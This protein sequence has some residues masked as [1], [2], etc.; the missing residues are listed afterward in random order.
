MLTIKK[1]KAMKPGIFAKGDILVE[2]YWDAL[3]EMHIKWVATRG[4]I[5]DWAIYYNLISENKTDR[6]IKDYGNKMHNPKSI[7]KCVDCDD[8]AFQMYRH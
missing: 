1:L 5:H 3:K 4:G 7:K 8:E 2:D 6:E